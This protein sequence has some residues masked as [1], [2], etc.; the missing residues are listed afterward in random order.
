MKT[1]AQ[2]S[3]RFAGL[4]RFHVGLNVSDLQASVAFYQKVFDQEPTKL[5]PGYAKFEVSEPSVNFTLNQT[6]KALN[7]HGALNHMGIQLKDGGQLLDFRK[8]MEAFQLATRVEEQ[9]YCCYAL[10]DKF[11]LRDPDGNE[12]EFFV[13][14]N[15][16]EPVANKSESCCV[17]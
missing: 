2:S 4:S 8:K 11:W 12:I 13:V 16:K 6:S 15:E 1:S 17:G 10:Q 14:L 9:T 7:G 5:R 3:S